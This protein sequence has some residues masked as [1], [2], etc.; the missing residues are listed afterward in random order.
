MD[1][2]ELSLPFISII[3]LSD[4]ESDIMYLAASFPISILS[5]PI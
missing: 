5:A 2:E 4:L 3:F 1:G